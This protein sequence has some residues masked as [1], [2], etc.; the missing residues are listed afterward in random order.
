MTTCP[1]T[2]KNIE[3]STKFETSTMALLPAPPASPA[4]VS[5]KWR[6]PLTFFLLLSGYGS[7]AFSLNR[8]LRRQWTDRPTDSTSSYLF[9]SSDD[10]S[11]AG[12]LIEAA[13]DF[14]DRF[15]SSSLLAASIA[16]STVAVPALA[17]PFPASAAEGST[18]IGELK[19]S[20]L[21][22]KDTLVVE[23]FN[24]PKVKGVTLYLSN[25]ER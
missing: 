6:F 25:F 14:L 7:E 11:P 1:K 15:A 24:D 4:P 22:F 5:R 3:T 8:N 9:A 2:K 12:S 23:R 17:G 19:G 10:N 21:V 16:L 13:S 20:G 18:V